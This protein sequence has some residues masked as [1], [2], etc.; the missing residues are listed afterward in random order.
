MPHENC[1][2]PA[3]DIH[4]IDCPSNPRYAKPDYDQYRHGR[5]CGNCGT[6]VP[7]AR[8]LVVDWR[9]DYLC[10]KCVDSFDWSDWTYNGDAYRRNSNG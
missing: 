9:E 10:D 8:T 4:A 3:N 1:L 2:D 5:R 7:G 6:T